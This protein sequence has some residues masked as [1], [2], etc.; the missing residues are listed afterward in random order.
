M[1]II[2]VDKPLGIF[3]RQLYKRHRA[4]KICHVGT[5]DYCAAG[6][7]ILL[8]DESTKLSSLIVSSTKGYYF[9]ILLGY[10]TTTDDIYG[11]IFSSLKNFDI[12]NIKNY[13]QNLSGPYRQEVPMISAKRSKGIRL[14]KINRKQTEYQKSE[15]YVECYIRKIEVLDCTDK[16]IYISVIADGCFYVR[17]L[18]VTIR[19]IFGYD[20]CISFIY[21]FYYDSNL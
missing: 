4:R 18:C 1:S 2:V 19:K 14:Y 10:S 15:K 6:K 5:L 21:R 16:I 7:I 13:I 11:T 12:S 8:T 9:S 3:T 17:A 20:S